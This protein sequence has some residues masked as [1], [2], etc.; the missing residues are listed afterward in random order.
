VAIRALDGEFRT[1][2]CIEIN[3]VLDASIKLTAERVG[4]NYS[5][6]ANCGRASSVDGGNRG[7]VYKTEPFFLT[8]VKARILDTETSD[9]LL[10]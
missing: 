4:S 5:S 2:K 7:S 9:F 3:D 1:S 8:T 6:M 10:F